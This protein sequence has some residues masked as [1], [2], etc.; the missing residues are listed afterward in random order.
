MGAGLGGGATEAAVSLGAEAAASMGV[1]RGVPRSFHSASHA[2]SPDEPAEGVLS[3]S[4]CDWSGVSASIGPAARFVTRGSSDVG[5]SRRGRGSRWRARSGALT[6][7][8]RARWIVRWLT[9]TGRVRRSTRRA[10][11]SLAS[12]DS[13]PRGCAAGGRDARCRSISWPVSALRSGRPRRRKSR[14]I[15]LNISSLPSRPSLEGLCDHTACGCGVVTRRLCSGKRVPVSRSQSRC[16]R[17]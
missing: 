17:R 8:L 11:G 4:L 6:P 14:P 7:R 12:A 10:S 2:A 15:L 5:T 13:P 16:C 1:D 9:V 3:P